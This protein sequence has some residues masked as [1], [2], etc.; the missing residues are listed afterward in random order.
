VKTARQD[1]TKFYHVDQVKEIG[2]AYS[3]R[4]RDEKYILRLEDL[5]VRGHV[6]D[7]G[8]DGCTIL[9]CILGK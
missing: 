1:F 5:K 8:V 2:R 7:L 9:E 4:V 6:E 3:K